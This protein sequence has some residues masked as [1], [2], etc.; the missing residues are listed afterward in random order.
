MFV[1]NIG[2]MPKPDI[3][4]E[5]ELWDT[6]NELRGAVSENNYKIGRLLPNTKVI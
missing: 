3:H 2:H 1:N 4:F 6:A 5:K